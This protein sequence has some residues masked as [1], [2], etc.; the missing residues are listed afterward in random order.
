MIRRLK[1][2]TL[3]FEMD[4]HAKK[5]SHRRSI[6]SQYFFA[7]KRSRPV[8]PLADGHVANDHVRHVGLGRSRRN[9]HSA[10]LD[11]AVMMVPGWTQSVDARQ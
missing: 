10:F 4:G 3:K 9:H 5:R 7:R 1:I 11:R 8:D 6:R 2:I